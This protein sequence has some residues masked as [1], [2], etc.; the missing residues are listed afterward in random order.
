[1]TRTM[2]G[3]AIAAALT[4]TLFG[5]LVSGVRSSQAAA[6]VG[7]CDANNVTGSGP[8]N[9]TA[10]GSGSGRLFSL[11]AGWG[12][13]S[14]LITGAGTPGGMAGN[15]YVKIRWDNP[16]YGTTTITPDC[17]NEVETS[18]GFIEL[19]FMG[20]VDN[21]P[22]LGGSTTSFIELTWEDGTPSDFLS[23]SL[24]GN[25]TTNVCTDSTTFDFISGTVG[26]H[27]LTPNTAGFR[28]DP[29]DCDYPA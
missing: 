8:D 10:G 14:Y 20:T 23:I 28:V 19:E 5:A 6:N 29:T 21:W 12:T 7:A 27:V 26:S 4:L 17:V 9:F 11:N 24:A 1:M 2:R 13:A 18:K 22:A 16:A 3:A 25:A 15:L